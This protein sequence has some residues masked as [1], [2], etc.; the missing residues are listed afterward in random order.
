MIILALFVRNFE[1]KC[2]PYMLALSPCNSYFLI[3]KDLIA[4]IGLQILLLPFLLS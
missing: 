1:L 4:A 2:A 3:L